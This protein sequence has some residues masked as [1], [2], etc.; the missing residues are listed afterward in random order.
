[1]GFGRKIKACL[2]V[3]STSLKMQGKK[4]FLFFFKIQPNENDPKE[5]CSYHCLVVAM[6]NA[7]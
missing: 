4:V 1:M 6:G 5:A 3:T 2:G 7:T